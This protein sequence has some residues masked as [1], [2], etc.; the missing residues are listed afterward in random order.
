MTFS[1]Y[2]ALAVVMFLIVFKYCKERVGSISPDG[3]PQRS[4]EPASMAGR[5]FTLREGVSSLVRNKYWLMMTLFGILLLTAYGLIGIYPYYAQYVLGDAN[6]STMLFTFRTLVEFAGVFI[7]IPLV[8]WI[9]KR[10]IA[11]SGSVA[12]VVGQLVV[13]AAPTS[14][15]VLLGGLSIGGVGVGA[16]FAVLFGMIGDTIEYEQWRSGIR[17]EGL[18]FAGATVG[19]KIGGALGGVAIGWM[20][21]FGGF[22][23]GGGDAPQPTSA[24]DAIRFVF[25]WLPLIFGAVMAT[26]MLAYRLDKEYPQ[27]LADLQDRAES[28]QL[29]KEGEA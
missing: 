1:L 21:G 12:V 5:S 24:I 27:I 22:I 23:E 2:G 3:T 9:G 20:L 7:A 8:K 26:L 14:L 10:N 17:A 11:L 18:V 13:A 25:I 4:G 19:Q 15:P 16:M 28:V 29:A 6:L